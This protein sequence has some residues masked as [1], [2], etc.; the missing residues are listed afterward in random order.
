MMII[1]SL[2]YENCIKVGEI[3]QWLV[4]VTF[5]ETKRISKITANK[6]KD[7]KTY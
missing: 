6:L 1:I 3:S 5:P 2:V 7:S 4:K